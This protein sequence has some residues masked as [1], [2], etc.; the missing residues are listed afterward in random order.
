MP[1]QG[2]LIRGLG[3][4]GDPKLALLKQFLR[5]AGAGAIGTA[6]QYLVL[7]VLVQLAWAEA[8]AASFIGFVCGALVN[9]LLSRRYVFNSS[10][11]HREAVFKFFIVAVVGLGINTMIMAA[12][13]HL[14]NL[15]YLLVQ[16]IATGFV[17]LWNFA[18]NKSWTFRENGR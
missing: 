6:V 1:F 2:K 16:V 17:L 10:L 7:I 11:P 18:G 3:P 8:V 5:F 15:H 14:L 4:A 9:Y 12:G 13:M